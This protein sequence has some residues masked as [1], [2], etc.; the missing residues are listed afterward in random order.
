[1]EG[2]PGKL[3]HLYRTES[4]E[5]MPTPRLRLTADRQSLTLQRKAMRIKVQASE[6]P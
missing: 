1:V 2:A 5:F 4:G 6:P 3:D